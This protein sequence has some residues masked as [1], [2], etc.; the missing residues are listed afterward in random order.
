M[1]EN[2]NISCDLC[3]K[4]KENRIWYLDKCICDECAEKI[5]E[6]VGIIRVMNLMNFLKNNM[7]VE[8]LDVMY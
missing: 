4:N 6:T 5:S 3:G 1:E 2:K 7:I 8:N